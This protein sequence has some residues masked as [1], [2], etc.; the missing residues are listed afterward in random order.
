MASL[1]EVKDV[2]QIIMP[3]LVVLVIPYFKQINTELK[4]LNKQMALSGASLE[5]LMREVE[6]MRDRQH[7]TE[8]VVQRVA[9]VQDRCRS[10][11]ED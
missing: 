2:A 10:C 9:L 4:E 1:S 3:L 6:K 7:K 11:N 8:N 5:Y